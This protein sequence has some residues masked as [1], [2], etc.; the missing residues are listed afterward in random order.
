M[1][2]SFCKEETE[3]LLKNPLFSGFEEETLPLAMRCLKAERKRVGPGVVLYPYGEVP[4]KA[5]IIL[6]GSVDVS[7]YS[8]DGHHILLSRMKKGEMLA[9]SLVCHASVNNILDFRTYRESIL[10]YLSLP[11]KENRNQKACPYYNLI[12]QNLV[13]HMAEKMVDLNK[14]VQILGQRT[15]R[16]KLICHFENLAA[17]QHTRTVTLGYTREVLASI[18]SADRS[19]V[20]RE[21]GHMQRD[22]LIV[23]EKNGVA[24]AAV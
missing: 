12:L 23:L 11:S 4:T 15:L 6:Q 8:T 9:E 5:A 1:E 22:G 19:A 21:L 24:L 2:I 3:S 7:Q 18:V 14:K 20:S 10:L 13:C 17:E 16:E